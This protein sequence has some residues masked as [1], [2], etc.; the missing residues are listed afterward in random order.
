VSCDLVVLV[1]TLPQ[2]CKQTD[3]RECTSSRYQKKLS[4]FDKPAYAWVASEDRPAPSLMSDVGCIKR[5]TTSSSALAPLGCITPMTISADQHLLAI[6][7]KLGSAVF[8]EYLLR[9]QTSTQMRPTHITPM[10]ISADQHLLAISA[11]LG[12][13]VFPEYLLRIQTS[14]QMRPTHRCGANAEELVVMRHHVMR[15]R[16]SR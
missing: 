7:A 2:D 11:K 3:R 16:V 1:L 8:P 4:P 15:H 6:S 13:A 12:S 5:I 14:T 9:I 10:T